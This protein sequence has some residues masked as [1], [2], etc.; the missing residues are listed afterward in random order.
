MNL[1]IAVQMQDVK[2]IHSFEYTFRF[3]R[4]IYTL[5]GENAVGKSTIMAAIAS[6]IYPKIL[7]NFG[8]TEANPESNIEFHV[9]MKLI[10][11]LMILSVWELESPNI[12][13]LFLMESMRE[14][15]SQALDLL[16]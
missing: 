4:G 5:V 3:E 1:D 12:L 7:S 9:K 6:T 10:D 15:S 16:T 11:I 2:N 13:K 8:K 14:V